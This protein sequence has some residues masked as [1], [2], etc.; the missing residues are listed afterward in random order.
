MSY[1][2]DFNGLWTL[3][4]TDGNKGKA[5]AYHPCCDSWT[6]RAA[7]AK[8]AS[9]ISSLQWRI[10]AASLGNTDDKKKALEEKMELEEW[11]LPAVVNRYCLAPPKVKVEEEPPFKPLG[12]ALDPE[13]LRPDLAPLLVSA[14]SPEDGLE[15][16]PGRFFL[17]SSCP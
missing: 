13:E 3:I 12:R 7:K 16:R 10:V 4:I 11:L 14:L 2:V 6:T 8:R 17:S 15:M 9:H 1:S 5:M